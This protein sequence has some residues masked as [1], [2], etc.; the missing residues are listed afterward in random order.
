MRRRTSAFWDPPSS[1]NTAATLLPFASLIAPSLLPAYAPTINPGTFATMNPRPAPH[2][3]PV[4]AHQGACRCTSGRSIYWKQKFRTYVALN[5][6]HR[7]YLVE[8]VSK[9]ALRI[10]S[11]RSRRIRSLRI[12]RASSE[13]VGKRR[14]EVRGGVGRVRALLLLASGVQSVVLFPSGW[15]GQDVVRIRDSLRTECKLSGFM[16]G[17]GRTYLKLLRGCLLLSWGGIGQTVRVCSV[18]FM[19]TNL[20]QSNRVLHALQRLLLVRLPDFVRRR[21]LG[22]VEDSIVIWE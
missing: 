9:H 10:R 21:Q 3:A 14:E 12:L 20:F 5:K 19:S 1:E 13:H 4:Q 16:R 7:T 22:N 17:K 6:R 11:V 15:L 18:P 8:H 2:T